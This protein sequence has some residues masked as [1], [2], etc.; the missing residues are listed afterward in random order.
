M[1]MKSS[2]YTQNDVT[3]LSAHWSKTLVC[4]PLAP[5]TTDAHGYDHPHRCSP[6]ASDRTGGKKQT[7]TQEIATR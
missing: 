1:N 3:K 6:G 7:A 4:F 5:G 2:N